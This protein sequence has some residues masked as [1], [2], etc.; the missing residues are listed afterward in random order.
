M[1]N[2]KPAPKIRGRI[3]PVVPPSLKCNNALPLGL[4][5]AE[6][7][8]VHHTELIGWPCKNSLSS[9][10][11]PTLSKKENF[12]FFLLTAFSYSFSIINQQKWFVKNA[13]YELQ[14]KVEFLYL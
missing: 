10:T 5:N 3:I 2:K 6:I 8:C 1:K 12:T 9:F 7:R 14:K 11:N 4:F 13:F